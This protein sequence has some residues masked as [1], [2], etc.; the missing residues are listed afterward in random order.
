LSGNLLTVAVIA[1]LGKQRPGMGG[2]RAFS[3]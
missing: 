1:P 2:F 3:I